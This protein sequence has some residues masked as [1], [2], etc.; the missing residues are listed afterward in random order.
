MARE[1]IEISQRSI[2][3][4]PTGF[5]WGEDGYEDELNRHMDVYEG[6][7]SEDGY[8]VELNKVMDEYEG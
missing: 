8:N 4:S 1:I 3:G 5:D 2:N 7:L 6:G